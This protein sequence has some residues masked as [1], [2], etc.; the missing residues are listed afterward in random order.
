MTKNN[1]STL[2]KIKA[3]SLRKIE[4]PYEDE[5][6]KDYVMVVKNSDLH[7]ELDKWRKINVRDAKLSS[8]VSKSIMN[9]LVDAPQTF[10][11][12][13]RGITLIVNR[14]AYNNMTKIVEIELNNKEQQGLLDGGHT[15][16]VIQEY[17]NDVKEPSDAYARVEI[18]EGFTDYDEIINI[19][20][21]RNKSTQ[22]Q[23]QGI[24]ELLHKFDPIK[25][26]LRKQPY[27]KNIAYK[28]YELG[29]DGKKKRIDIKDI[30]SYLI[31]FKTDEYNSENHPVKAY[32]Q[33]TPLVYEYA[34]DMDSKK[35]YL[36]YIQL[37]PEILMLR[38]E[39]NENFRRVYNS[40]GRRFAYLEGIK[41][42]KNKPY[43]LE[44]S[45]KAIDYRLPSAYVYPILAAFRAN[46]K[47]DSKC[48]EWKKSP[49]ELFHELE[50][51]LVSRVAEMATKINSPDKTAKDTTVWGRCYD[52]V[53]L[54]L[55]RRQK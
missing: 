3:F 38:D 20:H 33:K 4:S 22:V 7:N 44:F 45:G 51:G 9:T 21:A 12:R 49:I 18:L 29:E 35:T 48:C 39:I 10:Y 8:N 54:E 55:M 36:K 47:C 52:Y 26:A 13:N 15:F 42:C 27:R 37:L 40:V 17:L 6:K 30:L 43:V 5:G 46:I 32:T 1:I 31:C 28:E 2:L 19:V 25:K 50:E 11:F 16:S 14:L 34:D 41:E 53:D 23:E 24:Q